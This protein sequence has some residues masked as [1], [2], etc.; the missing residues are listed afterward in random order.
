VGGVQCERKDGV[1]DLILAA[2]GRGGEERRSL[3][4]L[5]KKQ[6]TFFRG[7]E[8]SKRGWRVMGEKGKARE[9]K[10]GI[11]LFGGG[12]KEGATFIEKKKGKKS[13]RI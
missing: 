13:L 10:N 11:Q 1:A 3:P 4:C 7:K 12:G 2:E 5:K 9:K 6:T 8:E